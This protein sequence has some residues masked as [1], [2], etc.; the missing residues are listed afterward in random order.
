MKR[1][2]TGLRHGLGLWLF[3]LLPILSAVLPAGADTARGTG[4]WQVKIND[5]WHD[6]VVCTTYRNAEWKLVVDFE[7][8][9]EVPEDTFVDYEIVFDHPFHMVLQ[10]W[11]PYEDGEG[12]KPGDQI[13]DSPWF[14]PEEP[15]GGVKYKD[16]ADGLYKN[17]DAESFSEFLR[18]TLSQDLL[19]PA[20]IP[21]PG[22]A[23]WYE[24]EPD[25]QVETYSRIEMPLGT[26]VSGHV[27]PLPPAAWPVVGMLG[28]LAIRRRFRNHILRK[29]SE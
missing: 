7:P 27:L 25:D 14:V 18:G 29:D 19:I 16:P 11:G 21:L 5:Q 13:D 6:A 12:L 17:F 3:G 22:T 10:P 1:S 2:W 9:L 28:V 26:L 15:P 4:R 8:P 20:N 24:G 23:Y